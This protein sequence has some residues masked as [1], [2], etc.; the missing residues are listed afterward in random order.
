MWGCPPGK[1]RG[2]SKRPRHLLLTGCSARGPYLIYFQ[3]PSLAFPCLLLI[4]AF[5]LP[6]AVSRSPSRVASERGG[7]TEGLLELVRVA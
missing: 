2:W 4:P 6:A 7:G 3:Q 5:P 1:V